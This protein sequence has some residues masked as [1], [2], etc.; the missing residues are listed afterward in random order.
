MRCY[1]LFLIFECFVI[2]SIASGCLAATRSKTRD[3]PSGFRR[4]C[5]QLRSVATLIPIRE[6]NLSCDRPY[7]SRIFRTSDS[8][9]SMLRE[10]FALPFM[11]AA[12]C[13]TLSSNSTNSSFFINI[14]FQQLAFIA[15]GW[16][17]SSWLAINDG[18]ENTIRK[19][20][21]DAVK[22]TKF[23]C[24]MAAS[25]IGLFRLFSLRFNAEYKAFKKL[26]QY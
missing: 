15:G 24:S 4:P 5:S 18:M 23:L 21:T 10:G 20:N 11:I 12:P 7:C 13:L 22:T 6:A 3:G 1:A 26:L 19:R 9:N 16:F 17:E 8:G 25:V 2:S 14:P